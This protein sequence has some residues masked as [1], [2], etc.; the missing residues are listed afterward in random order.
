M[1]VYGVIDNVKVI[2]QNSFHT[3]W[4][5]SFTKAF[6]S[7]KSG[8]N[9]GGMHENQESILGGFQILSR[10]SSTSLFPWD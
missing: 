6:A 2:P 10:K 9:F 3:I 1:S 8:K 5:L 4:Y 7:G